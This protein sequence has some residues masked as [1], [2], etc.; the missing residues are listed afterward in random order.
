MTAWSSSWVGT[1]KIRGIAEFSER[2]VEA[3]FADGIDQ[4]KLTGAVDSARKTIRIEAFRRVSMLLKRD[5]TDLADS[6][7]VFCAEARVHGSVSQRTALYG[8]V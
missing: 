1:S 7:Q 3:A 5:I 8:P 4:L 6:N 2:Q